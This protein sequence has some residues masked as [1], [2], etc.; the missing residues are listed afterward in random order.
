MLAALGLFGVL[1][2]SVGTRTREFGIRIALGATGS[3]LV[4]RVMRDALG[5]VIV[6]VAIGISGAVYV[7]RFLESLLFG[8]QPADPTVL[9]AVAILFMM[10]AAVASYVPARRA[11]LVDPA[12][13]LR[14]E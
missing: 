5:T 6:G 7:S 13:A 4:A 11:T 12:T 3:R 10:V 1:S 8:V 9:A 14:A 2:Y